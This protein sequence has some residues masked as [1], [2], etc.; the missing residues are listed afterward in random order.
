MAVKHD[1]YQRYTSTSS[2]AGVVDEERVLTWSKGY[3]RAHYSGLLPSDKNA[4]ILEVGCGYGRYMATLSDMGY[5]NCYGI[6]LSAEQIAYAKSALGLSN[7]EQA[8]ALDWLDGKEAVFD[9]IL[10]IDVLEHLGNDDLLDLAK[11]INS[12]LKPGGVVVFQVPNGMSPM[13]P[14]PYGDLTHVRAFTPQSMQQL[15]LNTGFVTSGYY[16]LPPY[17]HGI[18]SAIRRVLWMLIIKPAI[19]VFVRMVHG[20]VMGGAIFTSNFMAV[21]K[22]DVEAHYE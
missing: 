2:L 3:F 17:S 8:D 11:K 19:G 18:Q 1:L 12:A 5:T 4:K 13:N 20:K 9:C 7:L 14:V 10:A 21:A 15:F 22:R 6:D 16:E